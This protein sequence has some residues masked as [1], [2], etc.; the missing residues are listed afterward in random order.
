MKT[1]IFGRFLIWRL[2]HLSHRK[3]ILILSVIVGIFGG[4]AAIILKNIVH[5]TRVFLHESFIN[6]YSKFMY[7]AFPLIGILITGKT[8]QIDHPS[9]F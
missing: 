9:P 3:F 1:T 7:L 2:K 8:G 5:Y 4:L 6:D